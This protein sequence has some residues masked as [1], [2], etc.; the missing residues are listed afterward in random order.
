MELSRAGVPDVAA[1]EMLLAARKLSGAGVAAGAMVLAVTPLEYASDHAP[2]HV[3]QY[4]AAVF[5]SA[6]HRVAMVNN[7]PVKARSWCHGSIAK[8]MQYL[9]DLSADPTRTRKFDRFMMVLYAAMVFA[10]F[11]GV[12]FCWASNALP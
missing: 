4:G 2:G 8:R 3:G 10:L 11:A 5:G 1:S 12:A 9:H 6:L 7:I